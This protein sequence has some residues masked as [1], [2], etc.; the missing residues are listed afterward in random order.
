MKKILV[1]L[2]FTLTIILGFKLPAQANTQVVPDDNL[3]LAINQF[4]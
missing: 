2:A 4:S 3:R 1:I